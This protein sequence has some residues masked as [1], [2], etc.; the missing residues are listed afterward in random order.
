MSKLVDSPKMHGQVKQLTPPQGPVF[1]IDVE[2]VATSTQHNARAVAQI[3]LVDAYE[4]VHCN[5]YVRPEVA[6]ASYLQP[7]TG[8]T[9]ELLNTHGRPLAEQIENLKRALPKEAVL[10]GQNIGKD[11]EWLGLQEGVDFAS[12]VDLQGVWRVWNPQFKSYSV[13]SQDHVCRMLLGVESGAHNA[14]LD[15][16]KSVRL[17]NLYWQLASNPAQLEQ[18]RA[19]LL[20][21]P[22]APSF[23]RLNPSYE[24]V[25]MGNRKTCMCGAPFF[26]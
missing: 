10:V 6:V 20:S 1:S 17:F 21:E 16:C 14:V 22:P 7:L 9:A 15:A 3:S 11:C 23:A 13:F 5:L 25:C 18:A 19:R 4:R 2:C 12:L 24:G 26:G 8:L